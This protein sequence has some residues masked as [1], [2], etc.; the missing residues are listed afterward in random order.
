[1]KRFIIILLISSAINSFSQNN[2]LSQ[3]LLKINNTYK[4]NYLGYDYSVDTTV[5]TVK[6]NNTQ[7]IKSSY[8]SVRMN[9]LGYI[10]VKVPNNIS[11]ETFI[12]FL[13]KDSTIIKIEFSTIGRYNT[14]ND[15]FLNK[16]WYLQ[17]IN[18]FNAWNVTRGSSNIKVAVL[19]SGT[20]WEH[21]DLGTG[22]DSYQNISINLNEDAWT[23]ENNPST[24][25]GLDDDNNGLID[26]WKGWNYAYNNNDVRTSNFHG[27]FVAGIVSAKTNNNFG[28]AG[29]AGGSGTSG[30][31]I[32][33][34]CI[35]VN[36]PISSVLDDAIIDAVDN[37]A[38]IV[39]LSLTVPPS[40]AIEDAIQYAIN[41][42][43]NK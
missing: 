14:S 34:Y 39:Q 16:Q 11:F 37:G 33:P 13:E 27:T 6:T 8:S 35:G 4:V 43:C 24:G 12:S 21:Y 10:D 23:I 40:S 38:R 29:I 42:V 2:K 1:M 7:T 19:D 17:V 5:V 18:A 22:N 20:D 36:A 26:D 3:E 31:G 9:K 15:E 30:V 41:T 32:L 25:N 28:I